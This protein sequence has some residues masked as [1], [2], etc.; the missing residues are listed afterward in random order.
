LRRCIVE[1]PTSFVEELVTAVDKV[2]G[3]TMRTY[4]DIHSQTR[5]NVFQTRNTPR[6][7][8]D[9]IGNLMICGDVFKRH[10]DVRKNSGRDIFGLHPI[11]R[12]FSTLR[13]V[14]A[15]AYV[16]GYSISARAA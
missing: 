16:R 3:P 7:M 2:V 14:V 10:V 6:D 9:L 5:I 12:T 15:N 4:R 11:A 1:S 8:A 13:A